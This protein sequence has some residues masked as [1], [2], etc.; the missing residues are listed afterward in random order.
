MRGGRRKHRKKWATT[1]ESRAILSSHQFGRSIRA[2]CGQAE[3]RSEVGHNARNAWV[4]RIPVEY[5]KKLRCRVPRLDGWSVAIDRQQSP[6][7][8]KLLAKNKYCYM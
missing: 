2:W 5:V 6:F 3:V 7:N 8:A 4:G 1:L